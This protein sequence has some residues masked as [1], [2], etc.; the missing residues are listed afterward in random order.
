MNNNQLRSMIRNVIKETLTENEQYDQSKLATDP[1][2]IAIIA[3][4]SAFYSYDYLVDDTRR[5]E[6][7]GKVQPRI[8]NLS[9]NTPE[10]QWE[11]FINTVKY[12]L[13]SKEA[14][15]ELERAE[16]AYRNNPAVL[17][18]SKFEYAQDYY[19]G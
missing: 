14:K 8:E 9:P 6:V 16:Q 19:N 17:F 5:E 11:M 7:I 10:E 2:D 15:A 13:G 18:R 4:T 3:R 12:H 1:S